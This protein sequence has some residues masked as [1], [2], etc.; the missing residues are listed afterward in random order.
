MGAVS[1]TSCAVSKNL[2]IAVSRPTPHSSKFKNVTH[3]NCKLCML[4]KIY[5]GLVYEHLYLVII[6]SSSIHH[7]V[8]DGSMIHKYLHCDITLM[9]LNFHIDWCIIHPVDGV[10]KVVFSDMDLYLQHGST[11]ENTKNY[12]SFCGIFETH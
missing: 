11:Q 9:C 6:F 7:H 8:R 1:D 2:F 10:V 3:K 12:F 4:I 5:I